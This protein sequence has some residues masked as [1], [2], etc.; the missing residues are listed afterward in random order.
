[1]KLNIKEAKINT[2]TKCLIL[3]YPDYHSCADAF[4]RIDELSNYFKRFRRKHITREEILDKYVKR[5]GKVNYQEQWAGY[6]VDGKS[7]YRVTENCNDLSEK[8]RELKII[9]FDYEVDYHT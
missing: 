9:C 1:M 2:N 3:Q 6:C 5:T 4:F 8:E 7:I